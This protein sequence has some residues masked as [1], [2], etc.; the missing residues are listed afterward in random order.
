ML[1]LGPNARKTAEDCRKE[2]L[3]L[4]QSSNSG[5]SGGHCSDS[6]KNEA[7][8]IR[9]WEAQKID[10][11]NT[12]TGNSDPNIRGSSLSKYIIRNLDIRLPR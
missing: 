5:V 8:T 9:P 12:E 10:G 3:R 2:A 1:C 4:L 11:E 7:S 6:L